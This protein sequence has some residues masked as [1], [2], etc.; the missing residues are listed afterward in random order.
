MVTRVV[1]ILFQL[2]YSGIG[3]NEDLGLGRSRSRLGYWFTTSHLLDHHVMKFRILRRVLLLLHVGKLLHLIVKLLRYEI[4]HLHFPR[5]RSFVL[6]LTIG[7]Y[8]RRQLALSA[9]FAFRVP[10]SHWKFE[11]PSESASLGSF[12]IFCATDSNG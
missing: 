8:H 3:N 4:N 7:S 10:R 11:P 12:E 1:Q 6:I 2:H 9:M 5:I